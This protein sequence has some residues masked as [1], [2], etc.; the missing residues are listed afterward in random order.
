MYLVQIAKVL[1][2]H[3]DVATA[4]V[5]VV[6][7]RYVRNIGSAFRSHV[8]VAVCILDQPA[9]RIYSAV[10]NLIVRLRRLPHDLNSTFRLAY[11]YSENDDK[12]TRNA[13]DL[14]S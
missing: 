3:R 4:V 14:C 2:I 10:L 7:Q 8:M 9:D 5:A 6:V 1:R 11:Y 13:T 12:M